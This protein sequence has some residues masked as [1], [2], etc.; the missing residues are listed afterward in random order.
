M[1]MVFL[2]RRRFKAGALVLPSRW[3]RQTH[4]QGTES[5][6][7]QT[8]PGLR[9]GSKGQ[10]SASISVSER[11]PRTRTTGI[12]NEPMLAVIALINGPGPSAPGLAASTSTAISAS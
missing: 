8:Y 2:R 4:G 1:N 12:G 6:V 11:S 5:A 7:F 10:D 3:R 9:E